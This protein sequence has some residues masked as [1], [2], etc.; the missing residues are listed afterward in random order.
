M[1]SRDARLRRNRFR[2]WFDW[3]LTNLRPP[4]SGMAL[5]TA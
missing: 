5:T 2:Q 1:R 4:T 3:L